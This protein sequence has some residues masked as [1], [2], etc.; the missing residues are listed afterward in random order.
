MC[1]I[2][3]LFSKGGMETEIWMYCFLAVGLFVDVMGSHP[4]EC[5]ITGKGSGEGRG[6]PLLPAGLIPAD[7]ME[8]T[9]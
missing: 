5:C 9:G 6:F 4:L 8:K 3:V 7:G 2:E 1:E